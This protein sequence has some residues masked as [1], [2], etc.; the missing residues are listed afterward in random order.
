[1]VETGFGIGLIT[2]VEAGRTLAL[3]TG[4]L[5]SKPSREYL[6]EFEQARWNLNR[7]AVG[8]SPRD[9]EV[10]DCPINWTDEEVRKFTKSDFGLFLPEVCST[11]PEGLRLQ[12]KI[13]PG[14]F[15]EEQ[16]VPA[17]V[18]NEDEG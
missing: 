18:R 14:M 7:F 16:N 8:L 6:A 5:R 3:A 2:V 15:W 11:A 17:L 12:A 9:V 1:M 10:L 13:Y 4:Q